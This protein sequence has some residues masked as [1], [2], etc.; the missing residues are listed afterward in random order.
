MYFHWILVGY[1]SRKASE[2][3]GIGL[4]DY[5]LSADQTNSFFDRAFIRPSKRSNP[6][7]SL[8]TL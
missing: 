2:A 7:S 6:R 3:H 1:F 8:R 4:A 5:I